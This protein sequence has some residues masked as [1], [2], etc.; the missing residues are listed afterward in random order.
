MQASGSAL[1]SSRGKAA[2]ALFD[3]LQLL[4]EVTVRVRWSPRKFRLKRKCRAKSYGSVQPQNLC[5]ELGIISC[6]GASG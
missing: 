1:Y 2:V 4:L 6:L 3:A 5:E